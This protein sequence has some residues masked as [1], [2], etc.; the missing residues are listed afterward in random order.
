MSGTQCPR[1]ETE[2]LDQAACCMGKDTSAVASV[3]SSTVTQM[4]GETHM[5]ITGHSYKSAHQRPTSV[6]MGQMEQA[7]AAQPLH[8][9]H[10]WNQHLLLQ[11]RPRTHLPHQIQAP[12]LHHMYLHRHPC[13]HFPHP[14]Q[15]HQHCSQATAQHQA[16]GPPG[17]DTSPRCGRDRAPPD[18]DPGPSPR[19]HQ[20]VKVM[21]VC[22]VVGILIVGYEP[23]IHERKVP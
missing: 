20:S 7:Q 22:V 4:L 18:R 1:P 19:T 2:S 13:S 3:H 15:Q 23:H 5:Y 16:R 12:L 6:W 14:R 17:S 8:H 10:P 21:I 11:G 9:H